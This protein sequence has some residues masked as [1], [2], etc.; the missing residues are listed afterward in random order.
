MESE[1]SM[2]FQKIVL[3]VAIIALILMLSVIG[4]MMYYSSQ[5]QPYPPIEG[6]Q[7]CP[8]GWDEEDTK[9]KN[10]INASSKTNI[11]SFILEHLNCLADGAT[12]GSVK[13]KGGDGTTNVSY[14]MTI[15]GCTGPTYTLG[16]VTNGLNDDNCYS[17][18]S[19]YMGTN[20][21]I[22]FNKTTLEKDVD[23]AKKYGITWDGYN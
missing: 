6:T 9:C 13:C 19:G 16:N 18:A 23:W 8:D 2:S 5:N 12:D 15:A 17:L 3:I 1:S 14:T 7:R 20:I 11:G 10:T 4:Y 22:S 21:D